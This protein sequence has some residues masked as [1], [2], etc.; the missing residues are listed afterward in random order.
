MNK[1]YTKIFKEELPSK[2][3]NFAIKRVYKST[4]AFPLLGRIPKDTSNTMLHLTLKF[5]NDT[6]KKVDDL[7][8]NKLYKIL[9]FYKFLY[10]DI[11][12]YISY[13]YIPKMPEQNERLEKYTNHLLKLNKEINHFVKS[14]GERY[15]ISKRAKLPQEHLL[16]LPFDGLFHM[17]SI[18]NLSKILR[19]G[20]LSHKTA[21]NKGYLREDI[22]NS[23]VNSMRDKHYDAIDLNIHDCVPLYINPKNPML[24]TLQEDKRWHQLIFLKINPNILIEEHAYFSDGNAACKKTKIYQSIE[25]FNKLKWKWIQKD[26]W[27]NS[28]EIKRLR[29][30]EVLIKDIIEMFYVEEI[31]FQNEKQLKVAMKFF[32]NHYGIKISLDSKMFELL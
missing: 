19:F 12:R 28:A 21:H 13:A 10:S 2:H 18:L 1:L 25:Q 3:I 31:I 17:T 14:S 6:I 32:P 29:C 23:E 4:V 26:T 20:L 5:S 15:I 8:D 24:K 27:V 16:R 9:R 7:Y 30:S 22:S 11:H